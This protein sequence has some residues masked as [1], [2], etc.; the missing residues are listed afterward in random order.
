MNTNNRI[1]FF[2][3]LTKKLLLQNA[4]SLPIIFIFLMIILGFGFTTER[5]LSIEN[6]N[7]VLRQTAPS[8]I[9]GVAST[10]V[11]VA[12][13]IDLSVGSIVSCAGVLLA[14]LL[15]RGLSAEISF[16]F[17]LLVGTLV[18]FANGYFISYQGVPS[19]IVTLATYSILLGVAQ[20]LGQG[21][22]I[23]I[24]GGTW[25]ISIGQGYLGSIP[26]PVIIAGCF[27]LIF[28]LILTRTKF[29]LYLR[30][31]GSNEEA[32]RRAGVSVKMINSFAYLLNGFAAALAGI[33]VAARLQA[34]TATAGRGL[35]LQVIAAVVLGG[36]SLFGG[37]GTIFGTVLGVFSI[38]LITNG[39]IF[40]HITP[41]LVTIIQGVIL[42]VALW[43]NIRLF[44]KLV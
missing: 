31:I 29:G 38:A 9:V 19:F 28:W 27:A 44:S 39:L 42:L 5:F 22:S 30:G 23:P 6:I 17:V 8:L 3:D 25:L 32:V 7:N 33:M 12:A 20:L 16:I 40:N 36:T 37:R 18:G 43:V 2:F 13:G 11:V 1:Q 24:A 41:F 10:L 4:S 21:F 14:V 34:G 35:E 26:M 15:N